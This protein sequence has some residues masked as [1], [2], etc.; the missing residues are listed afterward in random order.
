[1]ETLIAEITSRG[2]RINNL[3]QLDVDFWR[4]NLRGVSDNTFFDFANGQTATE[5]LQNALL[6]TKKEPVKE[7]FSDILD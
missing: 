5:A 4:C 1:M 3:F 2:Y 7:N 6:K